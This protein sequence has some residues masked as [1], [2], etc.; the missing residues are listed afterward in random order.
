MSSL[1]TN[2]NCL[3]L[4]LISCQQQVVNIFGPVLHHGGQLLVLAVQVF[5]SRLYVFLTLLSLT[6]HHAGPASAPF[7]APGSTLRSP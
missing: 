1:F 4:N 2:V 7:T 3:Y 5:L 6:S